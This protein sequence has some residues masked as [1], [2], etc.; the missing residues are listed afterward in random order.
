M[1]ICLQYQW[2]EMINIRNIAGNK[3]KHWN[4]YFFLL[5]ISFLKFWSLLITLNLL[6]FVLFW[7]RCVLTFVPTYDD[8]KQKEWGLMICR[9]SITV[10]YYYVYYAQTHYSLPSSFSYYYYV[11]WFEA[12]RNFINLSPIQVVDFG[13]PEFHLNFFDLIDLLQQKFINLKLE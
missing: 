7:L 4:Y 3:L 13:F 10:R 6:S 2:I 5:K 12:S 11:Y 1:R 8:G 9:L